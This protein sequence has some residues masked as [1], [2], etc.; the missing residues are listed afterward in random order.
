MRKVQKPP[1]CI[2][3][4]TIFLWVYS[5]TAENERLWRQVSDYI[6]MMY[7][8]AY[9]ERVY[10]AGDG[11]GWIKA[12]CAVLEKSRFVL[13]KYHMMKYVSSSVTHL[14]DS[15]DDAKGEIWEALNGAKKKE[16]KK[17]YQKILN[18]TEHGRKR[19]EVKGALKYFLNNW[20]G[21]R[22]RAEEAGGVWKCCAE[23]QVSHVLSDRLSSRPMGWVTLGC[24][25]MAKLRAHK[26]NDGKAID[27]LKYQKRRKEK[28]EARK[29]QEGLIKELRKRQ[30]GWAY[31]EQIRGSIPGLEQRGMK[32]MREIIG[33]AL[34]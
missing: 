29:E 4:E 1:V 9:L 33:G 16:L 11:G 28:A 8:T 3:G 13:D 7:D 27:I 5:G 22:I 17:V 32:W 26:W 21:I 15:A 12:G 18:V 30:N 20:A 14:M 34:A 10:I 6:E 19:E 23:G 2:D 24:D 25:Q 31:A